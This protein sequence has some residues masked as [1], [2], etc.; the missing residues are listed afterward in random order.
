MKKK[1]KIIFTVTSNLESDQRVHKTAQYFHENGWEVEVIGSQNRPCNPNYQQ[2]Y[3]THRINVL[4]KKGFLFY[5][6]FNIRLF[7]LLLFKSANRIW[8][9]DT[10]TTVASFLSAKIK[11]TQYTQ[12]LHELFPE[13]PEVTNRKFVKRVW[14]KIEDMIFPHIKDGYTVC[15]SIADYYKKRY[16]INLTVVRNAPNR[17]LYEGKKDEFSH[18]QGKIIL[19]QGAVNEGR[20]I[21]WIID[22]MPYV[23]NATF[24]IIG[25]GDIS[26]Y[27]QKKIVEKK[28]EDRVFMMGKIPFSELRKYTLSADLGVCLLKE[29]GLSYY[30]SLPNRVFDFMQAHVPLLATQFPEI[31]RVVVNYKTGRVINH[32]EPEYLAKQINEMLSTDINHSD[33]EIASN[34]FNWENECKNIK[35]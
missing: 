30:Y 4:F 21:E 25:D 8:S 18:I 14:T 9:N 27:I 32:Y 10:D 28:I 13:V 17:K 12:D 15:Q 26:E 16:N 22:A 34:V 35:L 20:G 31:E 11:G 1:N 5:A 33:F 23:N 2:T 19:Y 24:V 7:F 6:E 29:K 3:K